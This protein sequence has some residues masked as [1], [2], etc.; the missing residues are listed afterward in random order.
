MFEPGKTILVVADHPRLRATIRKLTQRMRLNT[1]E[2]TDGAAARDRLATMVPDLALLDL[3]LPESSGFE[4]CEFIRHS[5]RYARI[6]LLVMSDRSHPEDRA[7]AAE[8]GADAFLAKPFTEDEL[9]DSIEDLLGGDASP[10][11]RSGSTR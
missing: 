3:I 11:L 6:P 9:R 5:P 10:L 1:I 7:H 2:C 4:L 8:A